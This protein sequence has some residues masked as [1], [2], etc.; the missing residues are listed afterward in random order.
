[1][2]NKKCAFTLV[3]LL[4]AVTIFSIVAVTLYSSLYA[5]IK[6]FRRV[7]ETM[8]FHQELRFAADEI[9]LDLRNSLLCPIY[10]EKTAAQAV[11]EPKKEPGEAEEEEPVYYFKGDEKSLTFVT[12]KDV[13]SKDNKTARQICC[14]TY[15]LKEGEGGLKDL[16]W[17][18]KY[19][20]RGFASLPGEEEMLVSN[21]VDM[22]V[23][24][25]YEGEDEEAPPVWLD[26]W[27]IEEKIPL[28]VRMKFSF[29]GPGAIRDFTKT[30]YVPVGV[31]GTAE[32]AEG[33]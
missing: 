9:A 11:L 10:E 21:I 18:A 27:E 29:K 25:S 26:K 22:Q 8:K 6:V 24:Y 14:V 13:L 31:L 5:G 23:F 20:G 16:M 30:V 1:M 17:M 7:Q 2:K 32:E 15:Y 33:L 12:L 3:E 4:V 19:Q 28:G